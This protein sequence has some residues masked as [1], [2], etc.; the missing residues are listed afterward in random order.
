[1]TRLACRLARR[2]D[3]APVAILIERAFAAQ[4]AQDYSDAGR[5]AFRMYVQRKTLEQRYDSGTIAAVITRDDHII[6]YIELRD[7][8]ARRDPSGC[9]HITLF[10]VDLDHQGLGLSRLLLDFAIRQARQAGHADLTIHASN[11]GRPIYQRLG[12]RVDADTF[13][14]D[15]FI[16]T[17][18]RLDLTA[19][20]SPA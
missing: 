1:M 17:P 13:N 14:L 12:F 2:E 5:V 15:G 18:M 10:F 9:D 20:S 19:A 7:R 11:H 8:S 4:I 3:M 16:A 6:G